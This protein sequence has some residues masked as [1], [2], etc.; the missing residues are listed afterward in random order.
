MNT[1]QLSTNNAS[2]ENNHF[3][4]YR[5]T[6]PIKL[7]GYVALSHINLWYNWKNITAALNNREFSFQKVGDPE[8]HVSLPDGSYTIED[9]NNFLHLRMKEKGYE[10]NDTYGINLYANPVYNRV[11]L[12]ITADYRIAF[13]AGLAKFLGATPLAVYTDTD[14]NF[15]SVP[16]VENVKSVQIHCNLVYNEYQ[17]DSSLLYNFTP[18]AAYGSL[19]SVEPRF[20]QWRKTRDATETFVEVWLTD[21]SGTVLPLE[22]D[23]AVTLQ[24]ADSTLIRV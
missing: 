3:L 23:W 20:A 5:F 12:A 9:L 14:E 21:Q 13:G 18:N 22:D 6:N 8:V 7:N 10:N 11:T 16:Q 15:P 24:V 4:R 2:T 19:L 17:K 1:L